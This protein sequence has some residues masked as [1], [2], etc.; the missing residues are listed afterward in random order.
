MENYPSFLV[1]KLRRRHP[2][3]PPGKIRTVLE[4]LWFERCVARMW[5]RF[6]STRDVDVVRA[7]WFATIDCRPAGFERIDARPDA[8]EESRAILNSYDGWVIKAGERER[9]KS[10]MLAFNVVVDPHPAIQRAFSATQMRTPVQPQ[11]LAT[12]LC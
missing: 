5:H 4:R 10:L 6:V 1:G 2:T 11:L 3:L 9:V 12:T 7:K 8:F